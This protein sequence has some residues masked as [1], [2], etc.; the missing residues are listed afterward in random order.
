M[1]IK[2]QKLLSV[3]LDVSKEFTMSVIYMWIVESLF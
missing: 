2:K 1:E 3:T